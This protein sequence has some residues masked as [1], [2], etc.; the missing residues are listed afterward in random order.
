VTGVV[1]GG[2]FDVQVGHASEDLDRLRLRIAGLGLPCD[3]SRPNWDSLLQRG[4]GLQ[5]TQI[6]TLL[7]LIHARIPRYP[8]CRHGA[9]AHR[10]AM[11]AGFLRLYRFGLRG[12]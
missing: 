1:A 5:C 4:F 8:A 12:S 11:Y 9:K 10:Q 2:G 3:R 6:L 7:A